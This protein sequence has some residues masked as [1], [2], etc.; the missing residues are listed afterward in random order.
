MTLALPM[1]A[2]VTGTV[3]GANGSPIANVRVVAIEPPLPLPKSLIAA[4]PLATATTNDKGEFELQIKSAGVI[5]LQ[6]RQD[7]YAPVDRLT[8]STEPAGTIALQQVKMLE[9][10]VTAKGAPVASARIY[11]VAEQ[12]TFATTTDAQGKYRLPDPATWHA[13]YIIVLPTDLA[14]AFH[15]ASTRDFDLAPGRTVSGRVV[16]EKGRGVPAAAVY[17]NDIFATTSAADGTFKFEHLPEQAMEFRADTSDQTAQSQSATLKL[18][19]AAR[20]SGVVRDENKRPVAGVTVMLMNGSGGDAILTDANGAFTSRLLP[21]GQY[22]VV[23]G[24]AGLYSSNDTNVADITTGDVRHDVSV[25]R[26]LPIEGRVVGDDGLPVINAALV[27]IFTS[28]ESPAMLHVTGA[29]SEIDGKFHLVGD[30]LRDNFTARVVALKPGL[31][32]AFSDPIT[33]GRAV[34]IKVTRGVEVRGKVIDADRK[35]V[36][37]VRIDPMLIPELPGLR[38]ETASLPAWSTT[39]DDGRF[40]ARLAPGKSALRFSKSGYIDTDQDIDVAANAKPIEVALARG[41]ELRGHVVDS[42]GNPVPQVPV[43][44]EAQTTM[45]ASDGSFAFAAVTPGPVKIAFGQSMKEQIV[46]APA[47]AL[48]LVLPATKKIHGKVTDAATGEPIAHFDVTALQNTMPFDAGAF[49]MDVDEN[50]ENVAIVAN[51]YV[52]ATVPVA[53]NVMVSLTHGR[54]VRG[55]VTDEKGEPLPGTAVAIDQTDQQPQQTE[56]DGSYEITG[57]AVDANATL[58]YV[59]DGFM[60]TRRA[61]PHG[62]EDVTLDVVMSRG[63]TLSGHVVDANGN[64]VAGASVNASS[65]AAGADNASQMTDERGAFRFEALSPAHYDFEAKHDQNGMRGAAHDVDVVQVHELTIHVDKHEGGTIRG[66]ITGISTATRGAMVTATNDDGDSRTASPDAN[67]NFVIANSPAGSVTLYAM[68]VSGANGFRTSKKAT[69]DVQPGAEV[70]V[71]LAFGAQMRVHGHVTSAG[72]PLANT[73]IVFSG[74][75][76]GFATTSPDGSY[77]TLLDGGEY[78]V[79]LAT[80]RKNL[81]FAQHIVVKDASTFDF[82]VDS[83]SV[84]ATVVDAGTAQP[85]A[86]AT[87]TSSKPGQTHTSVETTTNREGQASLDIARGELVTIIASHRGHANAS[88]DITA[89]DNA[90]VTLALRASPGAVVRIVDMR[91]GRSL[92]GY[93]IARDPSGRVVASSS[94][95]DA[96]GTTTLPIGEGVY[97]VSASADG[98]GSHTVRAQIPSGEIRVP[99][100]RGGNLSLRTTTGIRG[101]A[102]LVQPDG[103][104]YVRCWCSGI[105]EITIEGPATLVDRIAPGAYTLEV[106]PNGLK[107]KQIPVTVIEGQTVNVSID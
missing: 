101:S 93:V 48:K 81:P 105:A 80:N 96:D 32:P 28:A 57:I 34:T 54:K 73:M 6:I 36:A 56:A 21:R 67:G 72:L 98:Y 88:Q 16:D 44:A 55:R 20:V 46:T 7:G 92:T 100:P 58:A 41:A 43:M 31:P 95:T 40:V 51:G 86:G 22:Q 62:R 47:T 103:Q 13:S 4:K 12:I 64:A 3:T 39:G 78:D 52:P 82:N 49:E 83:S 9:G 23:A 94:D 50:T 76:A 63:M 84:L 15:P 77:E 97:Q 45:T 24:V 2:A 75:N 74:D 68:A 61:V 30:Y 79:T 5:D 17:A 107:P 27:A 60:R 25:V 70:N 90:T 104:P 99:L 53:E 59:K 85:I 11:A 35:P 89:G 29:V 69:V 91:D 42:K 37:G 8:L 33:R 10:R 106:T 66:R 1:S 18:Q 87:V 38:E 102:R 14:P 19:P 71:E 26:H 65:A